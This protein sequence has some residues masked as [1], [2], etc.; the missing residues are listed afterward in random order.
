MVLAVRRDG[1]RYALNVRWA[2]ITGRERKIVRDNRRSFPTLIAIANAGIGPRNQ[3]ARAL[4]I[5]RLQQ[6]AR[7]RRLIDTALLQPVFNNRHRNLA[8]WSNG[9][10]QDMRIWD[11]AHVA[12]LLAAIQVPNGRW[13][14]DNGVVEDAEVGLIMFFYWISFPRKLFAMQEVFGREYSQI[15]RILKCIWEHMD[16]RWGHLVTNNLNWYVANGRL[17]YYNAKFLAK[18]LQT[19]LVLAAGAGVPNHWA[20]VAL[21]TDGTQVQMNRDVR[22][23]FSG[24]KWY[25]CFGYLFTTG[26]DGMIV[27]VRGPFAGSI[28][29]H[30]KQNM[31][32][33]GLRLL[34]AQQ[35]QAQMFC[36]GTDKGFHTAV[37]IQPMHNNAINTPLQNVQNTHFSRLRHTNEDDIGRVK[38]L[39][40]YID[41][42]KVQFNALQPLGKFFRVSCIMMNAITI[43][44]GTNS[45]AEFYDCAPTQNIHAYF[46]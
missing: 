1:H 16:T 4:L 25:Y 21:M 42:R 33:L 22:L 38:N 11:R 44:R 46:V 2:G 13:E 26:M 30:T 36:T 40:K 41:Y 31:S 10:I 14:C 8:S 39:C 24:H 43:L 35:G 12:P 28:N 9:D 5:L 20:L 6:N 27:D 45:T 15:S 23:N 19:N 17:A 7:I 3:L 29:D 37:C 18:Y 32:T 34:V